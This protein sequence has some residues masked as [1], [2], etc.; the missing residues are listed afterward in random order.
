MPWVVRALAPG[1]AEDRERFELAVALTRIT[2]PYLL[3]MTLVTL[4][5]G[6]LNAQRRFAVAAGAPGAAQPRD[7]GGARR[8]P[9]CSPNAAY[10]AAWG[11]AVSGVLQFGLLWWGCRRAGVAPRLAAPTLARSGDDAGSS[12]CSGRR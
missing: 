5:S 6:I 9:S 4:L 10:A 11:V 2:F 12:R 3:F 1:F 7:A 8:W